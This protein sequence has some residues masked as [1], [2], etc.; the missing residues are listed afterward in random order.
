MAVDLAMIE[1]LALVDF[2]IGLG[3]L[4][5]PGDETRSH[6]IL[7]ERVTVPFACVAYQR[8][9][10]QRKFVDVSSDIALE[11]KLSRSKSYL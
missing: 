2:G 4:A 11:R 5:H 6:L 8:E 10:D 3:L 9:H 1:H 7:L